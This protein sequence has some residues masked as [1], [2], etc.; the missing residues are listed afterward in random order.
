VTV[1]AE[2]REPDLRAI[3][4]AARGKIRVSRLTLEESRERTRTWS[5]VVLGIVFAV[6]VG[7]LVVAWAS[8]KPI[9]D[10]K[11]LGTLLVTPTVTLL[12]TGLGFYF[13]SK[14]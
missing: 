5:V 8:G 2:R 4:T 12:G 9:A 11:E 10:V 6:E 14:S 7:F 1:P 3:E 13:S